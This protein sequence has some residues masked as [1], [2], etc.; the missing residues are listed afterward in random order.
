[1]SYPFRSAALLLAVCSALAVPFA[2]VQAAT[3]VRD[4]TPDIVHSRAEFTVSHLVVSKVWGHIPIRAI[5]LETVPNGAMPV[6]ITA[7]LD[8]AHL[9]T[10]NHTRDGELR[11][12]TY[13]DTEHYPT[14]TF[15]STS[16]ARQ[17][18]NDFK[19]DGELTI[20]NVTK[21]VSF[22]AHLEGAV[23]DESGMTRV[24]YSANLTIDRRDFGIVDQRLTPAGVLFVG[25]S[26]TIGLTVEA[27]SKGKVTLI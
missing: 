4:W 15:K 1:M 9:D 2:P 12:A 13:F 3:A 18:P 24:G 19:V 6:A 27:L 26:V 7:S 20:K 8:V 5:T 16:V 23:P 11:S 17:D 10:D 22:I 21:P 25:N 14:M